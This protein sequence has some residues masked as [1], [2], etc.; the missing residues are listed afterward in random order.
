MPLTIG[1]VL[2]NRYR[3]VTKLGEGGFGAVYRAW[4]VNLDRPR[5]I[6]EN[7][8]T[9]P[10][11][12]RQ[13]KREAQIL[14]KL[15]HPN[16][17]RVIDHFIIPGQGQY[18]VMDFVEGQDLAEMLQNGPLPESRVLPWVMQVCDALS[19]LHAQNPPV[20]HRDIKPA[21]IKITPEGK[22]MLVDFGISK[23][24]DPQLSTTMGA[25]AVTPGYSPPEQ[26]GQGS[27]DAR[28]DLYALGATL[29]HLLTGQQPPD[30]VDIITHSSP[31]PPPP[32]EL[33][34]SLSVGTGEAITKAMALEREERWQ[35]AEAFR[36]AITT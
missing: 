4:D 15:V 35:S 25:R 8:D 31:P 19:Y 5:A 26:Y 33:N 17:P 18:L 9:S 23:V 3:I 28:S 12:Q 6:K 13:F 22:A 21:N 34:P 24:Y 2:Q 7:L 30:S 36:Q 27:T 14:D 1:E 29:Y 10:K 20:I 32:V 11:A 16:L